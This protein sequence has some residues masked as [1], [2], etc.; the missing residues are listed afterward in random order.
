MT[1]VKRIQY[2][3]YGGP[4]VMQLENFEPGQPRA[5]EVLVRVRAAAANPMDWQIRSGEMKIMTGRAFP[6]GLGHDFAGVVEAVGDGV[7]RLRVGDEVL[8]ATSLT[9]AGAFAEM[10]IAQAR[11]V[12][13]KPAS[14]S[15]QEAAAIPIVGITAWQA[16]VG[17]GK[18]RPGNVVFVHGCL[19][20]VGRAASQIAV[21]RG[22]W[23]GGS[24][25]ATA[26]QQAHDLGIDPV[27][28]FDFDPV[29]LTGRFDIVL[30]TAGTLPAKATRML[31]KPGGR[32]IDI[33]PTPAKFV[34]TALPGPYQ[35]MIAQPVTADLQEI[36]R[37]AGSSEL[38][39]PIARTVP[40]TEA[41]P[42]LTEL[43]HHRTPKG[44]KLII[45]TG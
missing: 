24:C 44:G 12:V 26:T 45:T 28:E 36:A 41:I 37:A 22:A 9:A 15:F 35:V 18:L 21:A 11:T 31:L 17:K 14:L 2:H 29:P 25:R 40:L 33:K 7:T 6:R 19:G 5:G 39:L 27:V 10:V 34:R 13:K 23:V 32:I 42:A 30:D 20:G 16:L 3:K 1:M 38:R 43:E 8:G 4:E